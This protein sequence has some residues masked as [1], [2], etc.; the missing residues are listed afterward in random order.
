MS[1]ILNAGDAGDAAG[2]AGAAARRQRSQRSQSSNS[3]YYRQYGSPKA[4]WTIY[5]TQVTQ[6]MQLSQPA[7]CAADGASA[8]WSPIRSNMGYILSLDKSAHYWGYWLH[9]SSYVFHSTHTNAYIMI[10]TWFGRIVS[11]DVSWQF[12]DRLTD[13]QTNRYSNGHFSFIELKKLVSTCKLQNGF[14]CSLFVFLRD[15]LITW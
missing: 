13:R 14:D 7:C 2:A 9:F 4:Q 3:K 6:V 15:A 5:W 11:Q 8:S 12:L 1:N 10:Y